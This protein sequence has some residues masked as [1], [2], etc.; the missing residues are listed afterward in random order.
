MFVIQKINTKQ[1]LETVQHKSRLCPKLILSES[2]T[3]FTYRLAG[4]SNLHW[5]QGK[6]H[7]WPD[8]LRA[9][10]ETAQTVLVLGDSSRA[11]DGGG[12]SGTDADVVLTCMIIE[13]KT[14]KPVRP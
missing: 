13:H 9:G 12:F 14:R 10:I 1:Y 2:D 6:A 3:L 8:L 5:V 7:H 11:N 4:V